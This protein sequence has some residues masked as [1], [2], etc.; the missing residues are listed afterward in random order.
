MMNRKESLYA[1]VGGC[2][3]AVLTLMVCSFL[4]LGAQSQSDSFGE[5]TCTKLRVVNSEAKAV[6][7]LD[8]F[9][10]GGLIALFGTKGSVLVNADDQ[11][12]HISVQGN[13]W[14]RATKITANDASAHV[15][16]YDR[17][18]N[19]AGRMGAS[20]ES[21]EGGDVSVSRNG[22]PVAFLTT[23]D[24]GGVVSVYEDVAKEAGSATIRADEYG[25]RFDAYGKGSDRS[26]ASI[27]VNEFG[28]GA[29]K[30][31]DKNGYR[32]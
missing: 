26:R 24:K 12:G 4:P 17:D 29:V 15:M 7:V 23:S 19:V 10:E 9:S 28:N 27:G 5:I 25:G 1:V 13:R 31:W 18:G 8:T 16:V 30:T 21:K 2:A 11:G 32:Q 22:I 3:G 6:V 20:K 14:G